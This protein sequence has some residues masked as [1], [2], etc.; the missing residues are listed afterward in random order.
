MSNFTLISPNVNSFN[1]EVFFKDL[2]K[3]K[4]NAKIQMN[5]I[6]LGVDKNIEFLVNQTIEFTPQDFL[7]NIRPDDFTFFIPDPI[8]INIRKGTYTFSQ[9]EQEILLEMKK[10]DTIPYM[11]NYIALDKKTLDLN[12][13]ED[14]DFIL[15]VST[16][17]NWI[18]N[19]ELILHKAFSQE[20]TRYYKSTS[21]SGTYDNYGVCENKYNPYINYSDETNKNGFIVVEPSN[22]IGTDGSVTVG[23]YSLN[24]GNDEALS[25]LLDP[26]RT[27]PYNDSPLQTGLDNLNLVCVFSFISLEI[28]GTEDVARGQRLIIREAV[29]NNGISFQNWTSLGHPIASMKILYDEPLSLSYEENNIDPIGLKPDMLFGLRTSESE[30]LNDLDNKFLYIEL[31]NGLQKNIQESKWNIYDSKSFNNFKLPISMFKGL[32]VYDTVNKVFSMNPFNILLSSTKSQEGFYGIDFHSFQENDFLNQPSL[33]VSKYKMVMSSD[34]SIAVGK[35]EYIKTPNFIIP[36]ID[37]VLQDE[38]L[39]RGI[40]NVFYIIENF[41]S[42]YENKSYSV[43]IENLPIQNRKNNIS[44]NINQIFNGGNQMPILSNVY[45]PFKNNIIID[46]SNDKQEIQGH[47]RPY[48]PNVTEMNNPESLDLNSFK[49]SIRDLETHLLSEHIKKVILDFTI[50]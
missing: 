28:T 9:L 37:S 19:D 31:V 22:L 23:L 34:L 30:A 39:Q 10:I 45:F 41:N 46:N 3:I 29:D 38:L 24:Y 48:F 44:N 36:S 26:L 18:I 21:A 27:I 14:N 6:I 42:L 11:E 32:D 47:Y 40:Y 2:V 49:I 50:F 7:P 1:F 8:I 12:S 33:Y 35:N 17:E 25:P 4:S 5:S 13:S 43:C 16:A 20:S 15:A